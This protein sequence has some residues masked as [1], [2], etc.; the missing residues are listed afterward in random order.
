M[1]PQGTRIIAHET[2]SRRST[3][4]PHG[5]YGWYLGPALEHYRCYTVYITKTRGNRI[6]ETV[7]FFPEK[8]T[9]P[10]PT[11]Q[12]QAT[13][14][15]TELT[16]ALLYPQLA[17]LFCQVGEAQTLALERLAAILEG[18]TRRKTKIN[19]PPTKK[20]DNNAPPRVQPRVSPPRVPNTTAQN[21]SPH[22][23]KHSDSIPSSHRP[24][25]IPLMRVVTPQTP[26]S[27]VRCSATQPCNLSQYLMAEA[28][29]QANHCFSI[30]P[31]T[32]KQK[33][34]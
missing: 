22:H 20:N 29:N 2:P 16:R 28:L 18:A 23:N 6:V 26:H 27:M 24:L 3:W 7:E 15:A 14:A 21:M 32:Q 9:L 12:Y 31:H 33:T 34:V 1:A 10:F 19:V 17:G 11:P 25:N 30:L 4:A 5:L 8:F 13:K